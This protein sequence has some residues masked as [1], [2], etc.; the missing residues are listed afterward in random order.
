[1]IL[2]YRVIYSFKYDGRIRQWDMSQGARDCLDDMM[3]EAL[4][5]NKMDNDLYGMFINLFYDA[6]QL[7]EIRRVSTIKL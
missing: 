3:R 5:T 4:S 6:E 2:K 7:A 1:M